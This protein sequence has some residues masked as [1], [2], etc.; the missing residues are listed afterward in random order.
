LP[1]AAVFFGWA[2]KR[3]NEREKIKQKT[4]E[5]R[6]KINLKSY[7]KKGHLKM[8]EQGESLS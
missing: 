3:L 6:H 1:P 4:L 8:A 2:R 5:K 7:Y